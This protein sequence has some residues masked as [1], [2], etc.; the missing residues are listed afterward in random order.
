MDATGSRRRLQ[1]LAAMGY[2]LRTLGKELDWNPVNVYEFARGNQS[3]VYA[4][5]ADKVA[6][7]YDRL[8][9]IP[10][11][12][13]RAAKV[14]RTHARKKGFVPPLAWDE[15]TIDDPEAIPQGMTKTLTWEWIKHQGTPEQRKKF[16][17]ESGWVSR[18]SQSA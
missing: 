9:M 6:A 10:P 5:T 15:E 7:L 8:S 3:K 17:E 11:E 2:A 12:N 16:V 18:K 14:V 1:A 4:A 13:T